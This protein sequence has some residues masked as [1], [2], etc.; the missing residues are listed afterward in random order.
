MT[1]RLEPS[2]SGRPEVQSRASSNFGSNANGPTGSKRCHG[3]PAGRERGHS[4]PLSRAIWTAPVRVLAP[5]TNH[6]RN[7]RF[8]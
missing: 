2:C 4:Q 8:P 7:G 3:R 1:P 5:P 6:D